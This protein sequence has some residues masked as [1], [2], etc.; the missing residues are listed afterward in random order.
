VTELGEIESSTAWGATV[1]HVVLCGALAAAAER[2]LNVN[3]LRDESLALYPDFFDSVSDHAP[4][5]VELEL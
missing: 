4:V 5:L 1:D 3:V 2:V